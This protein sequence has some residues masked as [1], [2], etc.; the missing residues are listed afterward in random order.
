MTAVIDDAQRRDPDFWLFLGDYITDC[1]Y[2]HR[3]VEFLR[4]FQRSHRC[5]FIRGNREDYMISQREAPQPWEY[6]SKNGALRYCFEDL[7]DGDL[8]WLAGMPIYS[9]V[10]LPGC[11]PFMMCHGSPE[12]SNYHFLADT[13]KAEQMA[14]RLEG[15]GVR[16]M[17]CGHSHIPF[18]YRRNGRLIVNP[19]ALGMPVNDQTC[20]QYAV[21]DYDG[22]WHPEI[23]SVEYDMERTVAEFAESGLLEKSAVWGRGLVGTIRTGI[24]YTVLAVR[25]AARLSAER[26]LPITDESLW[27]EA[28]RELNIPDLNQGIPASIPQKS[29]SLRRSRTP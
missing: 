12:Q 8:D 14:D 1:P 10:E 22:E 6:G 18:I 2:P 15:Y 28:A 7:T 23:I 5:V 16:L 21:V 25:I 24:N 4:E 20:A 26:G 27:N 29:K 3:T 19:G 9:R 13:P 17:L 11:E